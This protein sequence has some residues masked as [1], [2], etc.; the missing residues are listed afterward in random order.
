ME[1]AHVL[2]LHQRLMSKSETC[3][4]MQF[5]VFM[6]RRALKLEKSRGDEAQRSV[7]SHFELSGRLMKV[8][9]VILINGDS[10]LLLA[11][12]HRHMSFPEKARWYVFPD[13][14]AGGVINKLFPR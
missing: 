6:R 3:S 4:S 2:M 12:A 9:I 14:E 8:S 1:F 13:A 7:E 11:R 5:C 10:A